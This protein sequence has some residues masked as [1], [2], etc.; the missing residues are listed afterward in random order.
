MTPGGTVSFEDLYR[1]QW[2]PM[3]RLALMLSGSRE[4]A[5]D[6]VQDAFLRVS[7]VMTR[8][9][10]PTAY[11]RSTV[12]NLIRDQHRHAEVAARHAPVPPDA[13]MDPDVDETWAALQTLPDRYRVALV[14]R[15]YGDLAVDDVAELIGCPTGTAK[16]LIH[17]GLHLLKERLTH[18]H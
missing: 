17:R 2:A 1:S 16:S 11:L 5:E 3:V 7:S 8:V 9:A 4:T 18:D 14:L 15:F 12:V 13:T 10:S 6:V